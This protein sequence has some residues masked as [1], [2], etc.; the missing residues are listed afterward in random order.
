M[1]NVFITGAS[2]GLGLEF[3]K[4]Y[5]EKGAK[6]IA[7]CRKPNLALK[8]QEL[9]AQ[10]KDKLTIIK[11]DVTKEEDRKEAYENLKRECISLDILINNAGII[12]GDEEKSSILGEVYKEDFL[13]VFQVNSIAPLLISEK[14]LPLL[15]KADQAKI[16]NITSQNGSITQRNIGGKYSYAASKAA[17]NMITK[18]LSHD[19]YE[20]GIVVFAVHP[21]W[22]RTDMGGEEAPLDK[23][24]PIS[25]IIDLIEKKDI[26]STGKFLSW[27]GEEMPW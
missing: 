3:T 20:K 1:K 27:E 2:R 26:S 10:Y 14:V 8:L 17:L 21:G 12:S 5:L 25:M 18:I 13:K 19:L 24:E 9:K 23:E 15:E 7:S 6:V 22:L 16:V 4:Q 11:L